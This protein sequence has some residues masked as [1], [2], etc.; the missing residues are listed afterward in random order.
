MSCMR[1]SV[2]DVRFTVS[3]DRYFVLVVMVVGLFAWSESV[4]E[5]VAGRTWHGDDLFT[6][7]AG[8][9]PCME[10]LGDLC[11]ACLRYLES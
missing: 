1:S 6:T 4:E 11:L 2:K 9:W 7:T 8:V 10:A 5:A 3:V